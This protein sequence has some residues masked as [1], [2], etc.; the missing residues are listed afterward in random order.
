MDLRSSYT[1]LGRHAMRDKLSEHYDGNVAGHKH[2]YTSQH[3]A[4]TFLLSVCS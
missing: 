4:N 1:V 2:K 3:S